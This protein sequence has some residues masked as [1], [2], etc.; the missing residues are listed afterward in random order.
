[1]GTLY[2]HGR[3]ASRVRVVQVMTEGGGVGVH[4]WEPPWGECNP[5]PCRPP[6]ALGVL[7][8]ASCLEDLLTIF[9]G[10]PGAAFTTGLQDWLRGLSQPA[11]VLPE[12]L[13]MAPPPFAVTDAQRAAGRATA[14][15]L[16]ESPDPA[17]RG[18]RTAARLTQ[19]HVAGAPP[20]PASVD[21][22]AR[23]ALLEIASAA[24]LCLAPNAPHE[25]PATAQEAFP[26]L[27]ANQSNKDALASAPPFGRFLMLAR[28]WS[29]DVAMSRLQVTVT[30]MW[31]AAYEDAPGRFERHKSN[32]AGIAGLASPSFCYITDSPFALAWLD[33]LFA[34]DS[35]LR[36][37]RCEASGCGRPFLTHDGRGT[38]CTHHI[39]PP[40]RRPAGEGDG[41]AAEEKARRAYEKERQSAK[42]PTPAITWVEW[43]ASYR[44]R[45]T[46][47]RK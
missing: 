33:F 14:Q 34:I 18:L 13:T 43:A 6:N 1:M 9:D 3:P 41:A 45:R 46:H 17:L 15:A 21:E 31:S 40:G 12:W 23:G 22:A 5:P 24:W 38:L 28:P 7:P 26:V 29:L 47:G 10:F 44:P 16:R 2:F 19:R 30:P 35:G 20:V 39:P 27:L 8:G 36:L 32:P 37:A 25:A 42:E 11:S 4:R